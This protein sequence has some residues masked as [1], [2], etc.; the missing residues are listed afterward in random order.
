MPKA[1]NLY[2]SIFKFQHT[3]R[4]HFFNL[5]T[6]TGTINKKPVINIKIERILKIFVMKK[7]AHLGL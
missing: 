7:I 2:G 5:F 3:L 6:L 4:S 1:S